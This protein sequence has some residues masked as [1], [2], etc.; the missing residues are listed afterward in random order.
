MLWEGPVPPP[1]PVQ[2]ARSVNAPNSLTAALPAAP[3]MMRE[4]IVLP[5]SSPFGRQAAPSPRGLRSAGSRKSFPAPRSEPLLS[6]RLVASPSLTRLM[7]PSAQLSEAGP[8]RESLPWAS[9]RAAHSGRWSI[10]AWGFYR[11]GSDAAPVSQGRVPIYGASQIGAIAQYRVRPSSRHDPRLY[12]RGYRAMIARG[13]SEGALGG[14]LRPIPRLPLRAF[15]EL[16]YTDTALGA[17]LR[18]SAFLV[19]EL[20]PQSLPADFSLEAYGQAGWVGGRAATPFADGQV[21][22]V[23]EL[24]RFA[25]PGGAPVRVSAGAG[26]WGGAQQDAQRLDIGP[27]IRVEWTM[28]RVPARLGIDWRQRVAGDAAPQDGLAA[29]LSTSF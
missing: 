20:P 24:V 9:T 12:L 2:A 17:E 10:D 7:P 18:P 13:E 1:R 29:T 5:L 23:R 19:T 11:E 25:A 14:S 8:A 15:A 4:Q 27:T 26:G 3:T 21:S 16:R 28:G 22:L 6:D